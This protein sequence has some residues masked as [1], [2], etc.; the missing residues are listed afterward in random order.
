MTD[1]ALYKF[2]EEDVAK[3]YDKPSRLIASEMGTGKT[4]EAIAL[5]IENSQSNNDNTLVVAPMQ[6]FEG[7]TSKLQEMD[8]QVPFV[9]LNPKS[10]DE[11]LR[12][13]LALKGGMFFVHW[14]A[15][16]LMPELADPKVVSWNHVIADEVHRLQ[17]R[18]SQQ[19]RA[20]KKIKAKYKTGLSGTPVTGAPDKYWSVLNWLYP[21][22]WRSYW[23]FYKRHVD[24]EIVYPQGYHKIKGPKNED[25]LLEQVDEFYVRHLKKDKCCEHHPEGVTPWLPDK[26]YTPYYVDL[27]P[28]QRRAYNDMKK[29]M[30]AWVGDQEDTPLVA[31]V[32]VAQMMRLQ[33][34][35]LAFA[36]VDEQN[37]VTLEE[38][39]SKLDAVMQILEDNP[40]ESIVV[41]S[42]FSQ[43]IRLLAERCRTHKPPIPIVTYTGDNRSTRDQS[44]TA[45]RRGD[46]RV[47]AGTVSAGG[48][49][50][51]GLQEASST[52]IFLDRMW[53]PALNKQAEDRLWRDGQQNAVQIIDIM[54][55]DT[56]DRGRHQKLETKWQWIKA[57]LG[58]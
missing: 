53:S 57:L 55:R 45:F 23:Q 39:S 58:S 18:K 20:L 54:A 44:V 1:F 51:D 12:R 36:S 10:R 13:F 22:F 56:V 42:Q 37:H 41:W 8:A 19:T 49:G 47:F 26:Y 52:V 32:V 2:Q 31:P 35:A 24:F 6:T 43:P 25:E 50:V 17:G 11:S 34:F 48:V 15:L 4:Y 46:A 16:R 21:Q 5:D 14:E 7:W 28:Q 29:D 40:D 38:P 9:V 3:L 30:I 33:Q 27:L